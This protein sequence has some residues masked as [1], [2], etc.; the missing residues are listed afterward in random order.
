MSDTTIKKVSADT[1][2][3]GSMGQ[4]Y[5]VSGT[6]MAMRLWEEQPGTDYMQPARRDY[7]TIGFVIMFCLS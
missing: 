7:E 1:S 5:L 6:S 3:R 4:K 2:P